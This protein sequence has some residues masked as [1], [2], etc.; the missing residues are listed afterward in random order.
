MV[1]DD[2]SVVNFFSF[3]TLP[4]SAPNSKPQ[5]HSQSHL[6]AVGKN[7]THLALLQN[8][9]NIVCLVVNLIVVESIT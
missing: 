7:K 5:Q 4:F 1:H 2:N 8:P 6:Q 3:P 9:N